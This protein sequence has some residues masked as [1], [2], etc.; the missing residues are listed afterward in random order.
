MNDLATAGP[1][2]RW[3]RATVLAGVGLTTGATFHVAADG[4]LPGPAVL[5]GLLGLSTVAAAPLLGAP[6]T[7]RRVVTLVVVWQTLVHSALA[8]LSGHRGVTSATQAVVEPH[9]HGAVSSR[10]SHLIGELTGPHAA[11]AV[12][13]LLAAVLVGSWLAA[14][15]RAVW[16][17]LALA[18]RPV[19]TVLDTLSRVCSDAGWSG[20]V[21]SVRA[22][23]VTAGA[24]G[25]C[26]WFL[27]RAVPRRGPPAAA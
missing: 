12:G 19:L 1:L 27:V 26:L 2:L 24:G 18:V 4:L 9:V 10:G 8:T 5:L 20:A 15:E 21:P 22:S 17:L 14:G 25:S 3:V 7:T 23:Q 6:A 13:H 11:M 16:R